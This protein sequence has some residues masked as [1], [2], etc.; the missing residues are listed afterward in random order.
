[1]KDVDDIQL[2]KDIQA[3]NMVYE[4][5]A[6]NDQELISTFEKQLDQSLRNAEQGEMGRALA[7]SKL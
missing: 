3:Q 6:K 1:M 5:T 7:V 4:Q 2:E